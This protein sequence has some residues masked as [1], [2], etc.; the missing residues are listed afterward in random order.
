MGMH[1]RVHPFTHSGGS[2]LYFVPLLCFNIQKCLY[3]S[4]TACAVAPL[5]TLCLKPEPNQLWLVSWLALL[6]LVNSLEMSLP[7]AYH[8][9]C[10]GVLAKW[11]TSVTYWCYYVQCYS[12]WQ[13]EAEMLHTSCAWAKITHVLFWVN[14][15]NCFETNVMNLIECTIRCDKG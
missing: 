9:Q 6:G 5:F 12:I 7:S 3:C 14:L 15:V 1:L 8:V 2:Y 11:N 13:Q 4:H 10:V